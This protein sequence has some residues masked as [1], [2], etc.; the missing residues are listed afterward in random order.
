MNVTVY[1]PSN[2]VSWRGP[3]KIG[4]AVKLLPTSIV[5]AREGTVCEIKPPEAA[6]MLPPVQPN[7]WS[8]VLLGISVSIDTKER[9]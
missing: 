2:L 4:R 8:A 3:M 1:C 9:R 5:G 7:R 6:G